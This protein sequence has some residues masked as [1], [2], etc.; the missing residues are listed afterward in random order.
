MEKKKIEVIPY[1]AFQGNCEEVVNCYISIF[2]GGIHYM[3]RWSKET[4]D[5]TPE[6][7][8][9]VCRH[10]ISSHIENASFVLRTY[11]GIRTR[12]N[13]RIA[14]TIFCN[15]SAATIIRLRMRL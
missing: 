2:G 6:Q 8:G 9:K 4:Y 11:C 12:N 14:K 15:R 7:I 5:R 13:P 10:N 1:L 3:S